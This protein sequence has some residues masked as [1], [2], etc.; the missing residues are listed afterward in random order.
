MRRVATQV[1]PGSLVALRLLLRLVY[2]PL[3]PRACAGEPRGV[4]LTRAQK[5]RA[6]LVGELAFAVASAT[7]KYFLFIFFLFS[8]ATRTW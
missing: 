4:A 2:Y 3:L 5:L 1:N 8:F 6:V 7:S